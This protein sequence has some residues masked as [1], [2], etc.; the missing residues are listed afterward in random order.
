MNVEY[1]KKKCVHV[2]G[3]RYMYLIRF[4]KTFSILQNIILV[5]CFHSSFDCK[6]HYSGLHSTSLSLVTSFPLFILHES[7]W[8][9][10]CFDTNKQIFP[11]TTILIFVINALFSNA[12]SNLTPLKSHCALMCPVTQGLILL[13]VPR[14]LNSPEYCKAPKLIEGVCGIRP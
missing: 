1:G 4:P 5:R 8:R 6:Q 14:K 3:Q 2:N 11:K 13:A 12:P 10:K 9:N 7:L